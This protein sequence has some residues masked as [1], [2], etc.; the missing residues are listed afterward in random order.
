MNDLGVVEGADPDL[1]IGA[2]Y[3]FSL[4]QEELPVVVFGRI[5]GYSESYGR[6]QRALIAG[7][8]QRQ[9]TRGRA[10]MPQIPAQEEQ[11]DLPVTVA[12]GPSSR[13]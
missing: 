11:A 3:E 4:E 2:L 10:G 7:V 12:T 13:T 8:R 9:G 1:E 6:G 5:N